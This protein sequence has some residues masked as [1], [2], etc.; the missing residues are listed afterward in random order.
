MCHRVKAQYDSGAVCTNSHQQRFIMQPLFQQTHAQK[1]RVLFCV[2]CG[3]HGGAVFAGFALAPHVSLAR[4][5]AVFMHRVYVCGCHMPRQAH[6]SSKEFNS[7]NYKIIRVEGQV[8]SYD[9]RDRMW[10]YRGKVGANSSAY[11]PRVPMSLIN[12]QTFLFF[13]SSSSSDLISVSILKTLAC[14]TMSTPGD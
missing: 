4:G 13:L 2:T 11:Q 6:V 12:E 9:S 3:A 14:V 10:Y 8:P 7:I 1:R 5:A